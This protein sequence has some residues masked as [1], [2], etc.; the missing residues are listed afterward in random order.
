MFHLISHFAALIVAVGIIVFTDDDPTKV[1]AIEWIMFAVAA[2]T[3][4]RLIRDL[5]KIYRRGSWD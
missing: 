1:S 2:Y 3:A 5:L 4:N